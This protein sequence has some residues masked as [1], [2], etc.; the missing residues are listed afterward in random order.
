MTAHALAVVRAAV[1]A[2]ATSDVTQTT[3]ELPR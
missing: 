1:H 2:H 3:R